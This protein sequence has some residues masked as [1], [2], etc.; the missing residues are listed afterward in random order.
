MNAERPIYPVYYLLLF[1]SDSKQ[2]TT[3]RRRKSHENDTNDEYV[4]RSDV[5]ARGV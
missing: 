5:F 3:K 1:Q 4:G 2:E